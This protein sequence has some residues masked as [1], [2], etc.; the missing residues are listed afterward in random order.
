MNG[1]LDNLSPEEL[2]ALLAGFDAETEAQQAQQKM[3]DSRRNTALQQPISRGFGKAFL[4]AFAP[5]AAGGSEYGQ[6]QQM[7]NQADAQ[8]K[9]SS[10]TMIDA[11]MRLRQDMPRE[12]QVTPKPQ[13]FDFGPYV[14]KGF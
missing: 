11:I 7:Q 5:A 9:K 2:Q 4:G 14:N 8:R 12:Q 6:G 13:P 10:Q 1:L 3:R